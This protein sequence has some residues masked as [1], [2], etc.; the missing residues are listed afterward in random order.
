MSSTSTGPHPAK[1]TLGERF[2]SFITRRP[3]RAALL[4]LLGF[5]VIVAGLPRLRANFTHTAFFKGNDPAL[6]RFEAFERRFGNDDAV[7]VVLHSPSGIFDVESATALRELTARMWKVP[8]VI[9]VDSLA[10]FQWVHASGDEIE[11][12]SLLP[13]DGPLSPELLA[14]RR[15]VALA[16]ETIPDYLVSR[17]AKTAL[18]YARIKPIFDQAGRPATIAAETRKVVADLSRGDHTIHLTGSP[19]INTAFEESSRHDSSRLVPLLL[20][21]VLLF[22]IGSF[23]RLGG[24]VMPL[25]VIFA[26]VL[27]ALAIGGW[28]GLELSVVTMTLPQVMIAVCV[29]DAV[30]LL[31][32]FYQARRR[33]FAR[34]DAAHHALAKNFLPTILTTVTTAAGFYSFATAKLP[35]VVAL[36]VM[37]GTGTI[38]AWFVTYLMLGPLMVIWPGREP[39]ATPATATSAA[40][41]ESSALKAATPFTTAFVGWVNRWRWAILA[42]TVVLTAG[43]TALSLRNTVNSDPFKY[44]RKGYPLR[45]AQE[46]VLSHLNGVVTLEMVVDSGV[47]DGIKDPA[48]LRKVEELERQAAALP[49]ITKAVSVVDIIRQTHRSLNGG[50]QSFYVLPD[51]R[52]TIAQ[53]LLLYTMSLPQ[54]MDVNDRISVK[55][56]AIRVTIIGTITESNA[57]VRTAEQLEAMAHAL[58]LDAKATGKTM[59]YQTMNG[60]VVISFIQSLVLAFGLIGVIMLAS[61][62]SIKLGLV[63]MIP[64]VLPLVIGGAVLTLI[65]QPLD[66][67]TV[68]VASVCLGIAV[69][70]TIHI[71]SGFSRHTREGATPA[72]ALARLLA[73]TGPAMVITT[74]VLVAGFGTLAFGTFVPN[75]F[76]GIMTATILTTG[77]VADLILLPA[78]LLMLR[79]SDPSRR[80]LSSPSARA[81]SAA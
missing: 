72:E 36:G 25:V 35:P 76:F 1:R 14:A 60:A 16:H 8:D 41:P 65:G 21:M 38:L 19:I 30:H 64:N 78:L 69:D 2:A 44:F 29:A 42:A 27:L 18:L 47:E 12:E 49:G 68:L 5:G 28:F 48:F 22:L 80:A 75:V 17:D 74:L 33:G 54:G 11:V 13:E 50:Q 59:L 15:Q 7:V 79:R 40:T 66:I 53:E 20:A 63:A 77:L 37:A 24:V 4:G 71:L 45:T 51:S 23:R 57:A 34:R 31:A 6:L 81:A 58:G 10:N 26:T 9:R 62:R 67:G 46:F 56:D 73:H 55:N 52:E 39:T 32:T 61:F 3:G 70:N 43:A